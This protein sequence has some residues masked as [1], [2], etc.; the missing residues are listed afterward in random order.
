[1]HTVY[2]IMGSNINPAQN[3]RRAVGLLAER[4]AIQAISTCWQTPPFGTDGPNF[5]NTALCVQSDLAL[6]ALKNDVL[7]VVEGILGRVRT[8][9]KYAPRPI[10]LDIVIYDGQVLEPALWTLAYLALPVAELLPDLAH[11]GSGRRLADIA[12]DLRRS[13]TAHPLQDILTGEL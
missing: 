7:R 13:G 3:T 8:V 11:P 10:D 1:M 9:D 12:E 6:E 4:V 2:L 5:I